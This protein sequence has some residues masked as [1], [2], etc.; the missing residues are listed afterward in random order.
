MLETATTIELPEIPQPIVSPEKSPKVFA[1]K[2]KNAAQSTTYY[3][4]EDDNDDEDEY[5]E[6]KRKIVSRRRSTQQRQKR[7]SGLLERTHTHKNLTLLTPSFG[8]KETRLLYITYFDMVITSVDTVAQTFVADLSF[9]LVWHEPGITEKNI[10]QAWRPNIIFSNSTTDVTETSSVLDLLEPE[11]VRERPSSVKNCTTQLVM[12]IHG[13]FRCDFDLHAFP[14]DRQTLFIRMTY[15]MYKDN[16]K[17]EV[18][19]LDA[20]CGRNDHGSAWHRPHTPLG[21]HGKHI[22]VN[23]KEVMKRWKLK[24]LYILTEQTHRRNLGAKFNILD[25]KNAKDLGE[26]L[27]SLDIH[28]KPT[29]FLNDDELSD[30][31]SDLSD[32]DD[33]VNER[34][35]TVDRL[36]EDP[37]KSKHRLDNIKLDRLLNTLALCSIVDID[38]IYEGIRTKNITVTAPGWNVRDGQV[39]IKANESLLSAPGLVMAAKVERQAKYYIWNIYFVLLCIVGLNGVSFIFSAQNENGERMETNLT[40]LLTAI[41]FKFSITGYIPVL[42]Y[43][44]YLDRFVLLSFMIS[45]FITVGASVSYMFLQYSL[46]VDYCLLGVIAVYLVVC[47]SFFIYVMTTNADVVRTR[48]SRSEI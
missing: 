16:E 17:F 3:P 43:L 38:S 26:L 39:Y 41:A 18:T 25:N 5:V 15:D 31:E 35:Q 13:E 44:T 9:E 19:F 10:G 11:E 48:W 34:R 30:I 27:N 2:S 28:L 24:D 47:S 8:R 12:N 22:F 7:F 20:T 29:D 6:K 46:L 37:G 14:F 32:A 4:V 21:P 45:I 1:A 33:N 42:P 40:L 36:S 23:Q